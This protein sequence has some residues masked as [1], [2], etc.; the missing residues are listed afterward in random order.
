MVTIDRSSL[1]AEGLARSLSKAGG[2]NFEVKECGLDPLTKGA[3]V[4]AAITKV[5]AGPNAARSAKP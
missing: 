5:V 1:R 2:I 3:R 4:V